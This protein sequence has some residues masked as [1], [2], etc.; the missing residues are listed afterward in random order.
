M[1]ELWRGVTGV[2]ERDGGGE[3]EEEGR[4]FSLFVRISTPDS[5]KE[6]S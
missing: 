2:V 4:G 1:C 6:N 3:E 5:T